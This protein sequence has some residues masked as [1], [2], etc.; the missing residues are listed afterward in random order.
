MKRGSSDPSPRAGLF[1]AELLDCGRTA[2]PIWALA[3]PPGANFGLNDAEV[4]KVCDSN[5]AFGRQ[6]S[7]AGIGDGSRTVSPRCREGV[8]RWI[9]NGANALGG[10][11]LSELTEGKI[12]I[13]TPEEIARRLGSITVKTL[14]ALIRSRG[15]E[16]TTLGHAPP[17]KR[18]GPS[19]RIWGMTDAQLECLLAVRKR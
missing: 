19:R 1:R 15:L 10:A 5:P 9:L 14:S 2:R 13:H 17:S 3:S 18:G 16:T 11:R 4:T 12:R 7:H 8:E 6:C